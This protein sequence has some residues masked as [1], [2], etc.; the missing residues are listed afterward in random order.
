MPFD[1][2]NGGDMVA[3]TKER[4]HRAENKLKSVFG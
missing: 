2:S 1:F 3:M 4:G